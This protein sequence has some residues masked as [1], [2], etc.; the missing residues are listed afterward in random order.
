MNRWGREGVDPGVVRIYTLCFPPLGCTTDGE[1]YTV[2]YGWE[3]TVC[4]NR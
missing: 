2:W 3:V 4:V 1:S